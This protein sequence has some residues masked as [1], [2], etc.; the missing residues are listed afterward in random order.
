[1]SRVSICN[2]YY[3]A[4]MFTVT[5]INKFSFRVHLLSHKLLMLNYCNYAKNIKL[6]KSFLTVPCITV[7]IILTIEPKFGDVGFTSS[8]IH[9][10]KHAF[11][12]LKVIKSCVFSFI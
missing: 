9:T 8:I 5:E 10:V 6:F 4:F 2:Q 12:I 7:P 11:L 3:S 1:M